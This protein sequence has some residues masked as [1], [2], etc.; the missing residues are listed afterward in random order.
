MLKFK[1]VTPERVVFE[2]DIDQATIMTMDGEITVLPHHLPLV[3]ALK[4]GEMRYK[5]NGEEHVL[6]V[7][8]GFIE[9]RPDNTVVVLADTAELAHEISVERADAARVR[10]EKLMQEARSKED[11]DFVAIQANLEK[12]LNRLKIGQKYRKFP[13]NP[14]Q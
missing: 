6:A 3:S 13:K 2:D 9:V 4:S 11:V 10:A 1:I 12:A 7:S 5:K 14:T 8:G